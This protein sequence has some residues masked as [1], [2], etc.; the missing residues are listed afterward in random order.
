MRPHRVSHT[1]LASS[2]QCCG[3]PPA[4]IA[5]SILG[6]GVHLQRWLACRRV[7]FACWLM[8]VMNQRALKYAVLPSCTCMNVC[9]DGWTPYDYPTASPCEAAMSLVRV[10]FC[11]GWDLISGANTCLDSPIHQHAPSACRYVAIGCTGGRAWVWLRMWWVWVAMHVAAAWQLPA[12]LHWLK[13]PMQ[14]M[15]HRHISQLQSETWRVQAASVVLHAFIAVAWPLA[16]G[17][18]P[19]RLAI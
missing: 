19:F 6:C 2:P 16:T 9:N 18:L 7:S 8:P 10:S 4:L 14:P 3:L 15:S 1:C 11:R 12:F 5:K 17:F 13:G